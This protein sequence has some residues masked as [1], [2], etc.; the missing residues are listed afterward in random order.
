MVAMAH[1]TLTRGNRSSILSTEY[2]SV[3]NFFFFHF[4]PLKIVSAL[5]MVVNKSSVVSDYTRSN[6]LKYKVRFQDRSHQF[7]VYVSNQQ[8]ISWV[9]YLVVLTAIEHMCKCFYSEGGFLSSFHLVINFSL[10]TLKLCCWVHYRFR[11]DIFLVSWSLF[12]Y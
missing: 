10:D 5:W 6:W 12:H 2:F 3:L 7:S 8:W 11:A 1:D 4:W 9:K